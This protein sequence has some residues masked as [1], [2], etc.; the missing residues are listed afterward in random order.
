M[1]IAARLRALGRRS[2]LLRAGDRWGAAEAYR[3]WCLASLRGLG[4]PT[5]DPG[6]MPPAL[7]AYEASL[8]PVSEA[9]ALEA[10]ARATG[11]GR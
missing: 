8:P 6:P 5:R 1:R 9:Q 4:G 2:E 3:E 11:D 10:L 7:A